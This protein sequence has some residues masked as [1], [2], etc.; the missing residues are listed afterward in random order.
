M[1]TGE[2]HQKQATLLTPSV[3]FLG[4]DFSN[5]QWVPE[6]VKALSRPSVNY[7][8]QQ[9]S[10][11]QTEAC[12]VE[13]DGGSGNRVQE[14]TTPEPGFWAHIF[15]FL[16]NPHKPAIL[17]MSRPDAKKNIS[18]LIKVAQILM[19]VG[20]GMGTWGMELDYSGADICTNRRP[21]GKT[22]CF[23]TSATW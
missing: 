14:Q 16:A 13:E 11:G 23:G 7:N 18:T 10:A 8:N 6:S 3:L 2:L 15:R 1:F 17:A 12:A 9:P 22:Q 5:N 19:P 20:R 4:L 21:L